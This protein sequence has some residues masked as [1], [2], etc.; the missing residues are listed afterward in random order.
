MAT[1]GP[2]KAAG[3]LCVCPVEGTG[4]KVVFKCSAPQSALS[5]PSL[6]ATAPYCEAMAVRPQGQW[7][8]RGGCSTQG[9]TL[10]RTAGAIDSAPA[11]RLGKQTLGENLYLSLS[12]SSS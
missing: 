11:A 4:G 6:C 7:Y 8:R 5:V 3:L 12:F 10:P 1:F 9:C 2:I